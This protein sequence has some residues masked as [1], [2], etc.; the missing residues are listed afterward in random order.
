MAPN[1][2]AS[3]HAESRD[4]IIRGE[5]KDWQ[6]GRIAQCTERTIRDIGQTPDLLPSM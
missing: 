4:M 5:L 2:A 1:L 6:M 3:Q